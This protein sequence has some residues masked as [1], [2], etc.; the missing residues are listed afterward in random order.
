[1]SKLGF[2]NKVATKVDFKRQYTHVFRKAI[3]GEAAVC[4]ERAL[5]S[6]GWAFTEE[7]TV[8][9]VLGTGM[10]TPFARHVVTINGQE[11]MIPW[12]TYGIAGLGHVRMDTND[13]MQFV[14]TCFLENRAPVTKWTKLVA[15]IEAELVQD[16]AR[17]FRGHAIRIDNPMDTIVP[18]I[19]DTSKDLPY[20]LNDDVM[21][22]LNTALFLPIENRDRLRGRVR[23]K[24][25]IIL[26]GQY[27]VGKSLTAYVAAQ[28]A[29]RNG[30]TFLTVR[31]QLVRRA[32]KLAALLQPCVV[33]VEDLDEVAHGNRDALNG[34]LNSLSG[35]E[36]KNAPEIIFL[37]STNFI[38]RLDPGF[39]R[40]ERIDAIVTLQ[41]PNQDT[42]GRLVKLFAGD[43][44]VDSGPTEWAALCRELE[45]TTPAIISETVERAKIVAITSDSR[46][47]CADLL[48]HARS[49]QRQRELAEPKFNEDTI[50]MQFARNLEAVTNGDYR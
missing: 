8:T 50:P 26:E 47:T 36:S 48:R 9:K 25:G 2:D 23:L 3:P 19:V 17:I 33:F 35:V 28:K 45:K 11:L 18:H 7:V 1:M 27:G 38:S 4:T 43:L 31:S 14:L 46:F 44:L 30:W 24:R 32:L 42:V 37:V 39:L 41:P 21:E 6:L 12:G 22:Q 20:I 34:L 10:E 15:Q 29:V 49:M 5:N 13:D 40:P 16:T